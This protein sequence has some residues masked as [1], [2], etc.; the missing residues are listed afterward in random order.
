MKKRRRPAAPR[1]S[2][3]ARGR[4]VQ[5]RTRRLQRE[6]SLTRAIQGTVSAIV[7]AC[8]EEDTLLQVLQQLSRLPLLETIVILNGCTDRSFAIVQEMEDITLLHYPERL[9]HDVGRSIGAS[10][11]SGDILLFVDGDVPVPAE[12]LAPFLIAI[13]QGLDVAL[14]D[15]SPWLPTFDRQDGVTRLKSFLNVAMGHPKLRS[16]SLTAV[17]HALSRKAIQTLGCECLSVPP[18]A[19][20]LALFHGLRVGAQSSADVITRNRLRTGNTGIGN[21]LA[22]LILGDHLEAFDEVMTQGNARLGQTKMVRADLAAMR[23]A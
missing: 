6:E 3:P 5:E 23:N 15:I 20:A 21:S 1:P 4:M 9:G 12:E 7:I 18:K 11:A 17:P 2:A 22:A 13:D 16:N 14:N 10:I 8:D 19:Q